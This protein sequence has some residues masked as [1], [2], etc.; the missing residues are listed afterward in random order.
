[1]L[2]EYLTAEKEFWERFQAEGE[3]RLVAGV[4]GPEYAPSAH[5]AGHNEPVRPGDLESLAKRLTKSQL[6][7]LRIRVA[8]KNYAMPKWANE[9][10]PPKKAR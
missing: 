10:T 3:R 7:S 8:R 4:F 5:A 2:Q 6:A 1:M 9:E